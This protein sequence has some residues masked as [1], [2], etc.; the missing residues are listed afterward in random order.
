M[1]VRL[2]E[3]AVPNT[4]KIC[5]I[6]AISTSVAVTATIISTSVMPRRVIR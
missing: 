3:T 5:A 2:S 1:T 4:A 6:A